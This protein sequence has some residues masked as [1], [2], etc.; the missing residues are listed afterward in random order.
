MAFGPLSLVDA[1]VI[2]RLGIDVGDNHVRAAIGK[3]AA[4]R[5]AK[6][7][8]PPVTI[9]TGPEGSDCLPLCLPFVN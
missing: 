5:L 6:P 2:D 1:A 3:F 4:D 8:P 7:C 9:A